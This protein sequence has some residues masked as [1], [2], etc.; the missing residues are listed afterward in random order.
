MSELN[1]IRQISCI[2]STGAVTYEE[3]SLVYNEGDKNVARIHLRGTIEN[4]IRVDM[5]LLKPGGEV[6]VLTSKVVTNLKNICR[7]FAVEVGEPGEYKCQLILS[8][9]DQINVSDIF[10]Y[11]VLEGIKGGK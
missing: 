10:S 3:D 7:E 1:K 9:K 11:K 6:V 5:K 2:I 4:F 8:Y